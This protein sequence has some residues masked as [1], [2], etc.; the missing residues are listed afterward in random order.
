MECRS[1]FDALTAFIDQELS[2]H[3]RQTVEDHL[4]RCL[5]CREEYDSLLQSY[6]FTEKLPWIEPDSRVWAGI[7]SQVAVSPAY[8]PIER[9]V[10]YRRLIE[11]LVN[12]LM[13]PWLPISTLAGLLGLVLLVNYLEPP[14]PVESEFSHFIQERERMYDNQRKVLFTNGQWQLRDER[15]PFSQPISFSDKNPFQE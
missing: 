2:P 4:D 5:S 9:P 15:N 10:T 12:W 14:N 1:C 3:D 6:E 13:R 7:R 11:V 8:G